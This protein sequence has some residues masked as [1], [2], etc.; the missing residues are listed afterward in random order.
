V[1]GGR[2]QGPD[3]AGTVLGRWDHIHLIL[4][5]VLETALLLL[6]AQ[7]FFRWSERRAQQLGRYD[8]TTGY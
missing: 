4:I 3:A 8:Q 5:L 2:S 1:G 7:V 6:R